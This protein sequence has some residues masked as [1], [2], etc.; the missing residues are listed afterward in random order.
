MALG[1]V[2]GFSF[3]KRSSFVTDPAGV[4]RYFHVPDIVGTRLP[5]AGDRVVFDPAEAG[6]RPG[7]GGGSGG[8]RWR[9]GRGSPGRR[10]CEGWLREEVEPFLT[11]RR[12]MK[13]LQRGHE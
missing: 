8:R 1:T 12:P 7:G 4:D 11:R 3:E 10:R 2:K 13:N 6:P 5:K 9:K